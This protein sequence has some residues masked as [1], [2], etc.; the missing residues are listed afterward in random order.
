MPKG[1]STADELFIDRF[2]ESVQQ[3]LP[4]SLKIHKNFKQFSMLIY[5]QTNEYVS[6]S[7]LRR[8]FQFEN[9]ITPTLNTLDIICRTVGFKNWNDFVEKACLIAEEEQYEI[10]SNLRYYGYNSHDDFYAIYKQFIGSKYLYDVV[11]ALMQSALK[12]ADIFILERFFD[13]EEI[14]DSKLPEQR[15]MSHLYLMRNVGLELRAYPELM[16][17]LITVYA[18]HPIAQENYIERFVDEEHL[19]GYWGDLLEEFHKHK[20]NLEAQLFYHCMMCQR[21]FQ[22]GDFDSEH[23]SFLLHFEETEPV[24]VIP[25]IRRLALLV[26]HY[27]K[28]NQPEKLEETLQQIP[29]NLRPELENCNTFCVMKFCQLVYMQHDAYPMKRYLAYYEQ[30]STKNYH[31]IFAKRNLNVLKIYQAFVAASD[32]DIAQAQSMLDSYNPL[33][34]IPTHHTVNETHFRSVQRYITREAEKQ[35]T[36]TH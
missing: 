7:T 28:T 14:F 4:F 10:L 1:I 11:F 8:I 36:G 15:S 19:N 13:L 18:A 17:K 32:G 9:S 6:E 29:G 35:N 22:D 21:D 12:K 5:E 2:K 26:I 24:Y 20:T 3:L 31:H 30:A 23:L 16:R 27:S 25:K 33:Y 34:I